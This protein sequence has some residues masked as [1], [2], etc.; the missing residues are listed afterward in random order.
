MPGCL[1]LPVQDSLSKRFHHFHSSLC[2]TPSSL[3][4]SL[5]KCDECDSP[6]ELSQKRGETNHRIIQIRVKKIL[7][8]HSVFLPLLSWPMQG[9]SI[10]I[11]QWSDDGVPT[12][13]LR[14]LFCYQVHWTIRKSGW[15]ECAPTFR[16]PCPFGQFYTVTFITLKSIL[17][18]FFYNAKCS[19]SWASNQKDLELL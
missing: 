8:G 9:W 18:R 4:L 10:S 15:S 13:S 7:L 3:W 14:T 1:T 16:S 2:Q 5:T 12:I 17:L 11:L 6:Q 19:G